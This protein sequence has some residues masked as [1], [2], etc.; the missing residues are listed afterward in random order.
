MRVPP[1]FYRK[2][3]SRLAVR[4]RRVQPGPLGR[5]KGG[6]TALIWHWGHARVN[7]VES[8]LSGCVPTG[9]TGSSCGCNSACLVLLFGV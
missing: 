7:V 6:N 2:E 3:Y 5:S 4:L 9:C 8:P 1:L